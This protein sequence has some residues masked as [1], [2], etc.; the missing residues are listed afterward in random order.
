MT[1]QGGADTSAVVPVPDPPDRPADSS[2]APSAGLRLEVP[3]SARMYDYYLGGK[4]N[5]PADREAAEQVLTLAPSARISAQQN[6]AFVHRAVRFL[7][8]EAGIDQFLDV[9]TGIPTP[10]NLHEVVQ[11][12][13]PAARVVYV[14]NDPIVLAHARALLTSSPEGRTAYLE[15]DLRRPGDIL[16]N[17]AVT[18]VLD[19]SRPVA[20]SLVAVLQFFPDAM[21]PAAIVR[22]LVDALPAGSHVVISHGTSD[23]LPEISRRSSDV[24]NRRGI[25]L[26]LRSR[27]EVAALVPA[28]MELVEPGVVLLHRWRPEATADLP[29]DS[30]VSGYGLIA[31]K[32]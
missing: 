20:L 12:V 29:A 21:G 31:R 22:E 7:A 30:D 19:L 1:Q 26:Q 2:E 11:A 3:H 16:S 24:Y 10:P 5:Y 13:T 28:G 14:D 23:V 8:E 6:R 4:T 25:P 27:A 18:D 32:V 17:P 9:G 15:A